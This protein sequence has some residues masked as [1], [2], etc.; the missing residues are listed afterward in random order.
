MPVQCYGHRGMGCSTPGCLAKYPENTI[1]SFIKAVECG[2]HGIELDVF[3]ADSG[4]VI[5]I[6]GATQHDYINVTA[7]KGPNGLELFDP[8]VTCET[9][10]EPAN[11]VYIRK[12]WI[13][14][15]SPYKQQFLKDPKSISKL[16]PQATAY[17][18]EQRE[19]YVNGNNELETVPTLTKVFQTLGDR[20]SYNIELKGRRPEL[21]LKVLE[22]LKQFPN[23]N[24]LISSFSWIPPPLD[25][26]FAT[27]ADAI[28]ALPNGPVECDLLRPIVN[29][30]Q[31]VPIGLLFNY[32]QDNLPCIE[33]IVQCARSYNASF[34]NI[35]HDFWKLG[36]IC[37]LESKENR[38]EILQFLL[39]K[40]HKQNLKVLSYW[41]STEPDSE[42]DIELHIKSKVDIICPND[43]EMASRLLKNSAINQDGQESQCLQSH[44][45]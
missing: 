29:N 34:I 28:E 35:K 30:A 41:L 45:A 1:E 7:C 37:G 12:P 8:K 2:A 14:L 13:L 21:G 5:V 33:R 24:V 9:L 10:T 23:L 19:P 11:Q 25:D 3:L 32:D 4:Q 27:N 18:S 36:T 31:Q 26:S 22:I 39:E 6:H 38:V 43:V 16:L 40:L 20:C 44:D 17:Y 42:R 15:D